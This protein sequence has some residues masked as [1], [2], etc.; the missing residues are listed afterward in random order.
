MLY[1]AFG[2]D[3][4][5]RHGALVFASFAFP[6]S[7]DITQYRVL[8]DWDDTFSWDKKSDIAIG[9]KSP[10][11]A[12]WRLL[13]GAIKALASD[14]SHSPVGIDWTIYS[15]TWKGKKLQT[16]QQAY[17]VGYFTRAAHCLGHPVIYVTPR[18]VRDTLG[19]GRADKA[20]VWTAF[21][22][23]VEFAEHVDLPK[24]E[25]QRDALILAYCV[26]QATYLEDHTDAPS[27][28]TALPSGQASPQNH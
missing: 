11:Q 27:S 2:F 23:Q 13:E 22:D 20:E 9:M 5:L 16:A 4:S 19:L 25:D 14:P 28:E 26:A 3:P 7:G 18:S 24:T 21:R 10:P 17:E 8:I 15:A 12:V 1:H 6:H